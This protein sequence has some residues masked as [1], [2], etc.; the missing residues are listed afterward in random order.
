MTQYPPS[1]SIV[2][3]GISSGLST[4][5]RIKVGPTTVGA[6]QQLTINQNR[7]ILVHE[8][9]GTDGVVDSHPKGAAKIDLQ[10]QR[11][12]FDN[13]RLPEAF[14]R[15]FVNI[16]AQRYPFDIQIIDMSDPASIGGGLSSIGDSL[17]SIGLGK[18]GSVLGS[19]GKQIS[20]VENKFLDDI[21]ALTHTFHNCWFRTY[22]PTYQANNF[23]ISEQATIQAEYVT[24]QRAGLSVVRGGKRG[25]RYEHDSIERSTDV[26]GRRGRFVSSSEGEED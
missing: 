18:V 23:I 13:L 10:V 19:V 9:V 7:E 6:I 15:G 2:D 25:I 8:E 24:T 17:G 5:I 22:S 21:N 16:H 11:I 20:K 1:G 26:F 12:V 3:K 14:S 4:Q